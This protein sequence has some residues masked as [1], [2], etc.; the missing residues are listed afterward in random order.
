MRAPTKQHGFT[1][2]ELLMFIVIV[3]IAA[4]A[5]SLLFAKNVQHS[6][7]PLIRQKSIAVAKAYFDEI[8]RK[9]WD[10]LSPEGGGCI[11]TTTHV[12]EA[13]WQA[14][15]RYEVG[16]RVR[17]TA[18]NS[19]IYEVSAISGNAKSGAGEPSWPT[20]GGTVV[21]GNVTW[22]DLG[23]P[24]IGADGTELRWQYD[25]VDDYHNINESPQ[26]PDST[27][28]VDGKSPMAG[29]GD[30]TVTIAVSRSAWEGLNQNDVKKVDLTVTASNGEALTFT[31][32]R[33]NY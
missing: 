17:P 30:F 32:Y 4:S 24:A 26:Y 25:D 3:G 10:E 23:T 19:H 27:D 9:R 6:A 22:T 31:L 1:F 33:V 13:S 2:I 14:N 8:V 18:F 11:D 20:G 21:D 28:A 12:C 29:Y 5:I 7:D 16:Q 15:T